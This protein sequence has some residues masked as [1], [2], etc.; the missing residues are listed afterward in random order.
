[1]ATTQLKHRNNRLWLKNTEQIT[2]TAIEIPKIS[3]RLKIT[4]I[5]IID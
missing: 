5:A 2:T 4:H 1:M 3:L